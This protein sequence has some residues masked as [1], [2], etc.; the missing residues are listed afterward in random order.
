MNRRPLFFISR[1]KEQDLINRLV[2]MI[3]TSN[4][5]PSDTAIIMASPDY[6]ATLAMH[7]SHEWSV[8]GEIIPIIPIDVAYPDEPIVDYVQKFR[9]DFEWHE[10][11][12]K[13]LILVEAGIIRGG[14]WDWLLRELIVNFNYTRDN[15]VLVAM[16]E[17][18]HSTIKSDYVGTYYNNDEEE[19]M[20]YYE[21]F[22]KHWPI[23]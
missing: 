17:N 13:K 2:T 1:E 20:F 11:K 7:L 12:Y 4:I 3:D 21:K 9:H 15:I 8:K 18:V 16:C 5:N 23:K 22:N 10:N 19:L 14:N 6:S